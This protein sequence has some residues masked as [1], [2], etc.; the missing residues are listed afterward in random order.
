MTA[1]HEP[2]DEC[3]LGVLNYKRQ[4][5]RILLADSRRDHFSAGQRI[6]HIERLLNHARQARQHQDNLIT[7]HQQQLKVAQRAIDAFEALLL[8]QDSG[9]DVTW[10]G[11]SG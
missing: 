11:T 2:P 8:P 9:D 3:R 7:L 10:P 6:E 4:Q 5:I 1:L